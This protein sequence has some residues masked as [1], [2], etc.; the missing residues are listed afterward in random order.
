MI[1]HDSSLVERLR[2][3]SSEQLLQMR[4]EGDNVAD[5]WH[6]AIEV[7][8]AERGEPI[9]PRPSEPIGVASP[10]EAQKG[11]ALIACGGL[12]VA[13]ILGSTLKNS[14]LAL[15]LG[16]AVLLLYSAKW[17]RRGALPEEKRNQEIAAEEAQDLG[18]N[19]LMRCA[20]D[21]NALR[22][23]EL[24]QYAAADINARST[25]GATALIY[26]ARNGHGEIVDLLIENG[27]QRDLLTHK[28]SSATSIARQFGHASIAN[29]LE[30][31]R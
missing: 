16:I 24:L 29:K 4:A 6:D 17:L 31:S 20:A 14:W 26:A 27:A 11:D 21:G 18:L 5:E 8:F 30:L 9:P 15:P 2:Q 13:A 23:R 28:G 3:R 19:E 10:R 22:V 1:T 7:I 25:A 12:L